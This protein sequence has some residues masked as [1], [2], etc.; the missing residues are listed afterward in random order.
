WR[1]LYRG[2]GLGRGARR[3]SYERSA[4]G[5]SERSDGKEEIC[6]LVTLREA[7]ATGLDRSSAGGATSRPARG[8]GTSCS[9]ICTHDRDSG[10]S[11]TT[12][13]TSTASA[14]FRSCRSHS[15]SLPASHALRVIARLLAAAQR[16]CGTGRMRTGQKLSG[17]IRLHDV[18]SSARRRSGSPPRRQPSS[19]QARI[20]LRD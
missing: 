16:R 19:S 10:M 3:E 1:R 5:T 14:P 13:S 6:V 9:V 20:L 8:P 7:Q 12:T 2:G 15:S 18:R 17:L 4:A 11:T